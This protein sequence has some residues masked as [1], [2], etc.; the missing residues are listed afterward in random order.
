MV[1]GAGL[2]GLTAAC[3]LAERGLVPLVLEARD[4]AGG[5]LLSHP[6]PDGAVV[7]L[8]GLGAASHPLGQQKGL[9]SFAEWVSRGFCARLCGW[10]NRESP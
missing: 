5:R 10:R 1:V 4:R 2:A 6:T 9:D 7:D 3:R 8:G